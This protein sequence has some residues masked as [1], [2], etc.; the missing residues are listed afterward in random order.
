MIQT[1]LSIALA[2]LVSAHTNLAGAALPWLGNSLASHEFSLAKRYDSA[3]V[4]DVFKDNILLTLA[5]LQNGGPL[6]Q[7]IDWV[8]LKKPTHISVTLAPGEVFAFHDSVLPAYQQKHIRSIAAHYNSQD[9]FK[10]DGF[11]YGDGVCHLASLLN[12]VARD[13]G[14]AVEAPVNH[15]F[16]TIP[17]VPREYGV[18]IYSKPT[19]DA[20]TALQNL[21]IT[22][23]R[24]HPVEIIFDYFGDTLRITIRE[25]D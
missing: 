16:A 22:N 1:V 12:W 2:L 24:S 5:I 17:E 21:Y 7:P 20:G 13:A 8:A 19:K 6:D 4:N 25:I 23:T 18:S 11:L 14:L 15:N 3:F 10:S 9:G